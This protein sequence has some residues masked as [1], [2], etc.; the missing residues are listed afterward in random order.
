MSALNVEIHTKD[1]MYRFNT[2]AGSKTFSTGSQ[3]TRETYNTGYY[4]QPVLKVIFP[5]LSTQLKFPPKLF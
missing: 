1:M 3:I 5:Y 2:R 4:I